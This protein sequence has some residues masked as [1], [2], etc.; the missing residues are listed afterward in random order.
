MTLPIHPIPAGPIERAAAA[1]GTPLYLYDASALRARAA[2]LR[3]ALPGVSFAYSLKAN[4]NISIVRTL[5]EEGIGAEICSLCEL[6][7]ALLAGTPPGRILFVGPAKSQGEIERA[8]AV[9]VRVVVA[10]S[11]E[12]IACIGATARR[13][14]RVQPIALRI[15]PSFEGRG[16]RLAMSGRATQFG[17][18]RGCMQDAVRTVEGTQ[19][20]RLD[21]LH[22]YMGTRIL[23]AERIVENTL[24]VMG[25]ADELEA[26][27]GEPLR[28]LDV[29]GGFGVPYAGDEATLEL[30]AL[31]GV[32]APRIAAWRRGRP[33]DVMFEL[34]RYLVAEA[35]VFVT[36]VLYAKT[37]RGKSFAVCD[38]GSNCHAAAGQA[39]SFRR[40]FPV[41]PVRPRPGPH[42]P[43]QVT[44]PLCTPTDV[45][46][47][48]VPM[49]DP[50]PGDLMRIDR[51]GAYGPTASPTGFLSFGAPA[52][53]M[54]EGGGLTVIRERQTPADILAPQT[55]RVLHAAPAEETL[56]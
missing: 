5:K 14:G 8:V 4:P 29:G 3:A 11:V 21:G 40:G 31:G 41:A 10:E 7:A 56:A 19:A 54:L 38:G 17:I 44:G 26:I 18:D 48:D 34:G 22:V 43:W 24:N 27:T 13:L 47:Q 53:A 32:L 42:R 33:T 20:L 35:G 52:E 37:T 6:E 23:E 28:L 51:S 12:E 30:A 9:G 55:P 49:S 1:L 16:A 25:L 46:A 36:R 2:A 45:V 15:N 50:R 39:A